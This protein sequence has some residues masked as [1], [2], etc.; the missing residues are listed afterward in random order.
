MKGFNK[1]ECITLEVCR[2]PETSIFGGHQSGDIAGGG[3]GG[4]EGGAPGTVGMFKIISS[5]QARQR[6]QH[7]HPIRMCEVRPSFHHFCHLSFVVLFC[8]ERLSWTIFSHVFH[9]L[10]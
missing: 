5:P 6:W 9:T 4:V 3:W 7:S 10:L 2:V 8:C 1:L